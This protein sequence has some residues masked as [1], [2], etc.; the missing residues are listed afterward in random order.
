MPLGLDLTHYSYSC[1]F[2]VSSSS[3]RHLHQSELESA[4]H[5]DSDF[6]PD[7]GLVLVAA[8]AAPMV[9]VE[10]VEAQYSYSYFAFVVV[11]HVDGSVHIVL[12]ADNFH[13][14]YI[15]CTD[16]I[17]AVAVVHSF[18]GYDNHN[19]VLVDNAHHV[20][21]HDHL[22]GHLDIDL[23]IH[24]ISDYLPPHYLFAVLL[25]VVVSAQAH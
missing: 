20:L 1:L 14:D 11:A 5:S 7:P 4:L 6:E 9:V 15:D 18:R 21:S 19:F 17:V 24:H 16:Y 22:H 13:F 25:V 12:V 3:L 23:V 10:P 2:V 8:V